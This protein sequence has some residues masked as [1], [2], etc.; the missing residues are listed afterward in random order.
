MARLKISRTL[1]AGNTKAGL[2]V[3]IR[4]E[5]LLNQA[6]RLEHVLNSLLKSELM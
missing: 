4:L 5:Y 2:T 1:S 3:K 6:R